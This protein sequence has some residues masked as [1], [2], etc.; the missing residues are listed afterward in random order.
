MYTQ[1]IVWVHLYHTCLLRGGCTFCH[2]YSTTDCLYF[3]NYMCACP[4]DGFGDVDE[5]TSYFSTFRCAYPHGACACTYLVSYFALLLAPTAL[6]KET[7]RSGSKQRVSPHHRPRRGCR[8]T[9]SLLQWIHMY[10]LS[11]DVYI[12]SCEFVGWSN[13]TLETTGIS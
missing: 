1:A 2:G 9:Y 6:I 11:R 3:K 12:Q 4:L 5:E 13:V 7:R 8:T 10:F